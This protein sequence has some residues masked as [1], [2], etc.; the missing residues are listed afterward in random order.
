MAVCGGWHTVST[1][2]RPALE[3]LSPTE[4]E[5]VASIRFTKRR[6]EYLTRRW[7]A[8]QAIATVLDI[9]RTPASL[10]R[11]EVQHRPSGA[12]YVHLDGKEA[13]VDVSMSDRSGWAVCLVGPSDSAEFGTLGIDLEVVEPRS[14]EFVIDFFTPAEIGHVQGLA[15]RDQRDEAA[16]LIWSAKEAALK[17]QQV[18]FRADTRTVEVQLGSSRRSDGWTPMNVNGPSGPMPGWW[19]RD[20]VFVLTIACNAH[21]EPPELVADRVQSCGRRA[22]AFVGRSPDLLT[23][24]RCSRRSGGRDVTRHAAFE[25]ID[26][27]GPEVG[28]S[29]DAIDRTDAQRPF[30]RVDAVELVGDLTKLLGSHLLGDPGQLGATPCRLGVGRGCRCLA[31]RA[32]TRITLGALFDLAGEHGGSRWSAPPITDAYDPSTAAISISSLSALLNTTKAP[33]W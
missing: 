11:I 7:T 10:A 19:R 15:D 9:G 26:H 21:R 16:N 6:N 20:G 13:E 4:R 32:H 14:D 18:G 29:D 30:D 28:G 5:Y 31:C 12:P 25:G 23:S 24:V 17:V 33:P 1:R 27:V 8:K 2:C 3:W 22:G